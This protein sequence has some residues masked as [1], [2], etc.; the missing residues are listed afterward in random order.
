M[1][2]ETKDLEEF[3]G[4]WLTPKNQSQM[5]YKAEI[6]ARLKECDK[7]KEGIEKLIRTKSK[8]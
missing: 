3:I 4:A 2:I 8:T 7:L 1:K 6:I 5:E